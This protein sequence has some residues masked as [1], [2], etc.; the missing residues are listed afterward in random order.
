MP[1]KRGRGEEEE[2]EEE[3]KKK[4]ATTLNEEQS[5]ALEYAIRKK[6]VFLTGSA[7]TGKSFLLHYIIK[8]LRERGKIV[9][10]TATTGIAA[11][12]VGGSTLYSAF[13]VHPTMVKKNE[14]RDCKRWTSLDVLVI[15]EISMIEPELFV[16][17]DKKAQKSRKN[18]SLF[19]GVQ[20]ILVGDFFQ[21]PPVVSDEAIHFVF[22]LPLYQRL[23]DTQNGVSVEL[24]QVFR[25]RDKN[26][27]DLLE[28]MRRGKITSSQL[29]QIE[30]IM[31]QP[32]PELNNCIKYTKLYGRRHDV[33]RNNQ[34]ELYKIHKD[35]VTFQA[36]CVF[37][38][39]CDKLA[40]AEKQKIQVQILKNMS[41]SKDLELREGAQVMLTANL[42]VEAGLANGSRGYIVSFEDGFPLV[43]FQK[44]KAQIYTHEWIIEPYTGTTVTVYA[45]PL[46][47]AY[48]LTIH[49]SQ[50]QSIDLLEIDLSNCWECGQCYTAFSRAT[51]IET[52]RVKNFHPSAIKTHEAVKDFYDNLVLG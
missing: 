40:T 4:L 1:N 35:N 15:D 20:L 50:G 37:G 3:A 5:S 27:V 42:D 28:N 23:F 6:N 49:K 45:L 11:I 32:P 39:N 18:K 26:F 41:M 22:Q 43:Q 2:E 33:D 34:E 16:Y 24:T 19:G 29:R 21:L 12:Q 38:S 46:K 51:S 8:D 13:S 14:V 31:K 25:Q 36:T 30:Q 9:V 48:A 47:L 10:V 7:G 44:C 52:L 17:L